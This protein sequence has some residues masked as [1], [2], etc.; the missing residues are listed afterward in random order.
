M[1]ECR[2]CRYCRDGEGCIVHVSDGEPLPF[3][4]PGWCPYT[5][6]CDGYFPETCVYFDGKTFDKE[7][8]VCK[9]CRLF[10]LCAEED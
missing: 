1:G 2:L 3:D 5:D 4:V 10:C 7:D 9:T 6:D 8:K